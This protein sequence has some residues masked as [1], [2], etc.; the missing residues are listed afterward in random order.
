MMNKP[1]PS[2]E[3]KPLWSIEDWGLTVYPDAL[4]RQKSRVQAI[5]EGRA[6]PALVFTEH[7][8]VIT[9]G[10][11]IGAEQ[12]LLFSPEALAERGITICRTGRGGDVT[13]HGPGQLVGYLIMPVPDRDLH[14]HLRRIE[15][16]LAQTLQR[17]G[18]AHAGRRAGL[19]GIWIE[20]RKI[21]AIGVAVRRWVA[22]H[23]F[24]LNVTNDLQPFQTIVPCGIPSAQ[25]LVTRLIDEID[26]CPPVERIKSILA[27][28]LNA[29]F[30]HSAGCEQHP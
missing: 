2:R 17:F 5:T 12:H 10:T 19:T 27:I 30:S 21:A 4:E 22:Y 15:N 16:G 6:T 24:A 7:H 25:G 29:A 23:G 3:P 26:P 28:E 14:G 9:I 18:L 1:T 11:R 20:N 13:Y 8:P